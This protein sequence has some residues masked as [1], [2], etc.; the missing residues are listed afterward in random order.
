MPKIADE[1]CKAM[2]TPAIS[3]II[4][5][6]NA[7][8]FVAEAIQSILTQTF[9]D[10]EVIVIDDGSHDDTAKVIA[11]IA[12]SDPR[13]RFLSRPNRGVSETRNEA[14]AMSRGNL[15]ALMDADDVAL[16]HRFAVQIERFRQ[17]PSLVCL[18]GWHWMIDTAGRVFRKVTAP[19]DN[20]SIQRLI[21]SGHMPVCNP[22][23]M[24]RRDAFL[25]TGG[26]VHETFPAE[27]LD[28][29][30]RL[31]DHGTFANVPDLLLKYR[32]HPNSTSESQGIAQRAKGKEAC[33]RAWARRGIR[34]EYTAVGLWRPGRDQ[35]SQYDY[36]LDY[37]WSAFSLGQR[38]TAMIYGLK[39]AAKLP[40]LCGG[41]KLAALAALKRASPIL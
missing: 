21:L 29:F 19:T 41:W 28:L 20:D 9:S 26:Y 34:G 24:M 6:Y 3:V 10:F 35:R 12:A 7:A 8:D 32:V 36:F 15:L 14:I 5:A 13:I 30:L 33:E 18:G 39:A 40:H 16:P 17:D 27:D 4:P 23:A 1:S 22:T 38:R 37:G 11:P 25:K 31:I 2:S